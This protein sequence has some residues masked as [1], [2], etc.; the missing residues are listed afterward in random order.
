MAN[1]KYKIGDKV[2]CKALNKNGVISNTDACGD[3][4]PY[5]V[6]FGK[7]EIQYDKWYETKELTLIP[8][9]PIYEIY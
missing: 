5:Y 4:L 8:S 9:T 7:R 1:L 6:K 3:G 2:Y